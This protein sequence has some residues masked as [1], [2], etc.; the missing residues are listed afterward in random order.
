MGHGEEEL[1]TELSFSK[2]G[3][4]SSFLERRLVLL[5]EVDRLAQSLG[6]PGEHGAT[7]ETAGYF[8]RYHVM[9]LWEP[10][11]ERA[12]GGTVQE[13]RGYFPFAYFFSNAPKPVFTDDMNAEQALD[14]AQ[15]CFR[16]L[17]K[18]FDEL[19]EIRA[20]ELL[21]SSYDRGNYLVTK[22]AKIIAMTC[23]HAALK[24]NMKTW[25]SLY[26]C[27]SKHLFC[28][29]REL[30]NLRF[31]Y[32]NVIMEEAAQILEVETFIPLL[33]QEPEEGE[34][35]LKRVVLIG[36]HN[37]LPPVVRNIAFQQYGNMEQSLFTRFVRLGVPTLQ[38]DA[39]V[40]NHP[41]LLLGYGVR[42]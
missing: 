3:R 26:L 18:I 32:D 10:Y 2:Y 24:V 35:R 22:E 7:C 15:G 41:F 25:S 34:S 36:D 5:Q 40:S 30:V 37:Q 1:N 14:A 6:I 39:Q 13:I 20:F 38:L 16:H 27:I 21:R 17:K 4:V 8:F 42:A 12:Q 19:E 23:T 28:K 29:R 33:L 31:R 9:T 11:I